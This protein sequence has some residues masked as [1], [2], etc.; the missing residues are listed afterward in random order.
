M[1]WTGDV[2][3]STLLMNQLGSRLNLSDQLG[4]IYLFALTDL[5]L[6]GDLPD[7]FLAMNLTLY[8][9]PMG[10]WPDLHFVFSDSQMYF[11]ALYF[12]SPFGLK[13]TLYFGLAPLPGNDFF[14]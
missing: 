3:A 2:S 4:R 5:T 1:R 13:D 9:D 12:H 11:L 7:K 8:F 14:H 10:T 6:A